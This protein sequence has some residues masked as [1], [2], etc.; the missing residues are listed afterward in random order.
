VSNCAIEQTQ[1]TVT[2]ALSF[3]AAPQKE[4]NI[5]F[6]TVIRIAV[7]VFFQLLESAVVSVVW[8]LYGVN[9]KI[10]FAGQSKYIFAG[11][12]DI[13]DSILYCT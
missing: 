3:A 13:W 8:A 10:S 2:L 6:I 11:T 7:G 1:Q 9:F 4:S 5:S 12:P